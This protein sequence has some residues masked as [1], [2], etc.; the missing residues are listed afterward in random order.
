MWWY[1][2]EVHLHIFHFSQGW[3]QACSTHHALQC[4][5][6]FHKCFAISTTKIR[7]HTHGEDELIWHFYANFPQTSHRAVWQDMYVVLGQWPVKP[8]WHITSHVRLSYAT[9]SQGNACIFHGFI[10]VGMVGEIV[11]FIGCSKRYRILCVFFFLWNVREKMHAL[12]FLSSEWWQPIW[13]FAL[14]AVVETWLWKITNSEL[15]TGNWIAIHGMSAGLFEFLMTGRRVRCQSLHLCRAKQN[16]RNATEKGKLKAIIILFLQS[17]PHILIF[18]HL[19]HI[20]IVSKV[21]VCKYYG[22]V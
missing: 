1:S 10:V 4:F 9:S 22:I 2:Q 20:V 18:S 12:T 11:I 7:S 21:S 17:R 16:L 8:L 13:S 15:Q 3:I 5:L 14:Y 19:H 6:P